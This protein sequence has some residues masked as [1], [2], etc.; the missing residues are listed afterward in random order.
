MRRAESIPA[1]GEVAGSLPGGRFARLGVMDAVSEDER[2]GEFGP[3][4]ASAP[5]DAPPPAANATSWTE[6][7]DEATTSSVGKARSAEKKQRNVTRVFVEKGLVGVAYQRR[8]ILAS[9]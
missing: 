1:D 7:E 6:D 9:W 2:G 3:L 8:G 4:S 5:G